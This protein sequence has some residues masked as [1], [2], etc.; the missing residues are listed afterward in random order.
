[1]SYGA[2]LQDAHVT[3]HAARLYEHGPE[4]EPDDT[5]GRMP[6]VV[7][8]SDGELFFLVASGELSM[9]TLMKIAASLGADVSA[10]ARSRSG[11]VDQK[12]QE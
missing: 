8:W 11:V 1:V 2:D 4:T 12:S 3:G 10:A 5:D 7:T 9:E 6:A